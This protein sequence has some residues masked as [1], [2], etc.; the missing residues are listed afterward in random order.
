MFYNTAYLLRNRAPR[1]KRIVQLFLWKVVSIPS[2][3]IW[4][5]ERHRSL[6]A[7]ETNVSEMH[8]NE[9]DTPRT[10]TSCRGIRPLVGTRL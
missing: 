9:V 4:Q 2:P 10:C 6:R 8:F 5:S 7:T 1:E 3:C